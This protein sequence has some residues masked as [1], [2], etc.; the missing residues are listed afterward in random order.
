MGNEKRR[1][2]RSTKAALLIGVLGPIL[3]LAFDVFIGYGGLP[4]SLEEWRQI[5]LAYLAW[6][7]G[8][9]LLS[10]SVLRWIANGLRAP[11]T[12]LGL[13]LSGPEE[14]RGGIAEDPMIPEGQG[15]IHFYRPRMH[16]TT[17]DAP[18]IAM[19]DKRVA[20]IRG[21]TYFSLFAVAGK[22]EIVIGDWPVPVHVDVVAGQQHFVR[23]SH[24][25][26]HFIAEVVPLIR[27]RIEIKLCRRSK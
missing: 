24:E 15:L 5:M 17:A 22:N 25:G 7:V 3:P 21:G 1:M 20:A 23:I 8:V 26:M 13:V 9:F 10:L 27:G 4:P 2:R 19:N 6:A 18:T 12:L 16:L 11:S 14:S